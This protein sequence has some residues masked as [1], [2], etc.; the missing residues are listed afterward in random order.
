MINTHTF[1]ISFNLAT[2]ALASIL[3]ISIITLSR[4]LPSLP[5]KN[6]SSTSIGSL[7]FIIVS[8]AMHNYNHIT[9]LYYVYLDIVII[10]NEVPIHCA[11]EH[12][13]SQHLPEFLPPREYT[14]G[15]DFHHFRIDPR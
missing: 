14:D 3:F 7:T 10:V 2:N 8:L 6:N 1:S 13:L 15:K 11:L 9:T 4:S 5:L 12:E